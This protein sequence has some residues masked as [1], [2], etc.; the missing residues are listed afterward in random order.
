GLQ[1]RTGV[2]VEKIEKQPEGLLINNSFKADTIVYTGDVRQLADIVKIDDPDLQAALENVKD[3]KSNGTSNL[4]CECDDND[5]I[6]WLYIPEPFTKAHRI[7]YTGNFSPN[8]NEGS[9]RK[10]CVVEFSGKMDPEVMKE[11]IKKLPGNLSPL[12]YNYEPNSYVI[13]EK[14]TRQKI[15]CLKEQLQKYNIYLVGRFAEWEYYN[16]DK[17]IEASLKLFQELSAKK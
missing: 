6:S 8:N 3:L 11:E 14:D 1:I 2:S 17:A 12:S 15:N 13:Q 9:K 16:M 5:N 10:T 7:I 4:F